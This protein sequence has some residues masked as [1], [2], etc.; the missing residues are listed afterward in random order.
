MGKRLFDIVASL[1]G[2][3][4]L[5]PLFLLI[6]GWIKID[7][8]GF[9][10]YCQERVGRYGKIFRIHKFRTMCSGAD[11]NGGL[12][13]GHDKRI[14]C[15]GYFLRKYKLDELPQLIDVLFGSM[16]LVGPRPELAEFMTK[17]PI[18]VQNKILS[19]R[20]GITDLASIEM[21]DENKIL[22]QSKNPQKMYIDTIMP[23]KAE[24]YIHYIDT[25]SFIGDIK[26]ILTTLNKILSN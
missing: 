22:G 19:V 17:Y 4:I 9:V 20:P 5:S 14:T 25:Q 13:I 16:S 3:I 1:C 10:F 18:E 21:I 24:F 11:K 6:A 2:L 12:T 8:P 15:C 23:R 7:S 26:I